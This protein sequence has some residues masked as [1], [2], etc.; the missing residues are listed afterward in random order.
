M[1]SLSRL[2]L[3]PLRVAYGAAVR[4]RLELYRSGALRVERVGAPVL[5]VGNLTAGGTGKTPLVEW[6]AREVA[7]R[8][9]RRVCVLTRGYAREDARRRVVV[10]DGVRVLADARAAGD[11]PLLLAERLIAH[12]AAVVCDADRGAAARFALENLGSEVFVL[13]DGFQHLRLARDLNVATVD[14]TDPWGGGRLLPAGLL[15]EPVA[16]LARADCVVV[17]RAELAED[18]DALRARVSHLARGR[19]VFA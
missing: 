7:T 17:T 5:S 10:S 15:R 11:E 9:G 13:D 1:S 12:G 8:E 14:A 2:A 18:L 16:Q 3:A 4:A 6:V 19:P